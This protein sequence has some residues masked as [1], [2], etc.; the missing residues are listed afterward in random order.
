MHWWHSY[1]PRHSAET[2]SGQSGRRRRI[3][4]R[5]PSPASERAAGGGKTVLQRLKL[6][7][8]LVGLRSAAGAS[9][10][11]LCGRSDLAILNPGRNHVH[12]VTRARGFAVRTRRRRA[13]A[14]HTGNLTACKVSRQ[15]ESLPAGSHH[16][17]SGMGIRFMSIITH[18]LSMRLTAESEIPIFQYSDGAAGG[19]RARA[20]E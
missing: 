9:V 7:C 11:R 20:R 17:N 14:R 6:R 10:D 18:S 2:W 8:R 1:Y 13:R 16:T 19:A 12:S 3:A 5:G 4:T 15:S